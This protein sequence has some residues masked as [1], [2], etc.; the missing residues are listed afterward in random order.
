[1][2]PT[3]CYID[4]KRGRLPPYSLSFA[5]APSFCLSLHIKSLIE[6]NTTSVSFEKHIS[7]SSR[8]SSDSHDKLTV[9]GCSPFEDPSD[10]VSDITVEN[11]GSSLG[12]VAANSGKLSVCQLKVETDALSMSNEGDCLRS[13]PNSLGNEVNI[14][15][16]S[17]GRQD[18]ELNGSDETV[19]LIERFQSCTESSQDAEKSSSSFPEGYSSPEKSECDYGSYMNNANAQVGQIEQSVDKRTLPAESLLDLA[20]EMNEYSIHSLNPTAPR[21]VRHCNGN[22]SVSPKYGHYSKSWSED[23]MRNGFI[24]GSKKPRTQVSYSLPFG[25][26]D[27]GSKRRSH[28]R[29]PRSYKKIKADDA[30]R[31]LGVSANSQCYHGPLTCNANVLVTV[32]DK[33]W[34]EC[35][36]QVALES[37][38]QKDWRICVKFSGVTKYAYKAQHILQPGIT[39]RHTHAM[40]WK[41]G[42]DW[43]LEFTNRSQWSFFKEIHEEC[44]NRNM[45][46]AYVKNIPIP[47]VRLIADD[48]NDDIVGVPFVRSS[49]KYYRQFG[50]EVDMALDPSH[51]IYDMD[52]DDEEWVSEMRNSVDM[53]G[54][55]ISELSDYMFERVMDIFE[56]YAYAQ[57]CDEFSSDEIVEFMADVGP[58]DIVKTI[59][60]HWRQKRLKKGMALVRQFKVTIIFL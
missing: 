3:V 47:G 30:K 1:M 23:F 8:E 31:L 41:G 6:S 26:F 17:V 7:S 52:S 25:G 16:N 44:F 58:L 12:Q 22:S 4:E 36:A 35:G 15:G 57:R 33:G 43:T 56:K 18:I 37:D 54:D 49:S 59:Y 39:N 34:R 24:S 48:D 2:D 14:S 20:W 45:R 40:M 9:S 55:D 53:K 5:T 38:D 50:T 27:L 11:I 13:S 32:G 29:K 60:E 51:V 21:S 42:K 19:V 10:Q 28:H 46:A